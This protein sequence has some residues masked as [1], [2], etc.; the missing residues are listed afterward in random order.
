MF[1][2]GARVDDAASMNST[3]IGE[4]IKKLLS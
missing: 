3:Q 2:N 4:L 1:I